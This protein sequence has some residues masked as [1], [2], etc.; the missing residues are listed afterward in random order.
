MRISQLTLK[1][2][3]CFQD[4]QFSFDKKF[5]V[6]EGNNGVGK[7]SLLEALHYACYL[8]SFR[9]PSGTDLI[10]SGT[11]HFFVQ[12]KVVATSDEQ[13]L[14][15]EAESSTLQVGFSEE[16]K[17]VKY[18][19]KAVASHKQLLTYY[20]VVSITEDDLELVRGAPEVRRAFLQQSL[21]LLDAAQSSLITQYKK[22]LHQR[23]SI[24]FRNKGVQPA[25]ATHEE[26]RIWSEQLW[27]LSK[28]LVE[29]YSVFLEQL[30]ASVNELLATYFTQDN[31]SISFEYIVKQQ[32]FA[33]ADFNSFWSHWSLQMVRD[34]F[35]QGRTLFG[36]HLDDFVINFKSVKAKLFASRGQQKLVVF[37]MKYAQF[38][39][40]GKNNGSKSCLLL[41]DFLTDFDRNRLERCLELLHNSN[42]QVFITCPINFEQL[43]SLTSDMQRILL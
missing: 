24:L 13:E 28:K 16:G 29:L 27:A 18:N 33:G 20:R 30:Q 35:A 22:V 39:L 8:R 4:Q 23:N 12:V 9:T 14:V 43:I 26:L 5:V 41:D 19:G 15:E 25:A 17:S 6:I 10:G 32:E 40:V 1:N 3:R 36:V 21:L 38:Y 11:P 42:V 31:F 34:E 37:L 7:T 2:F